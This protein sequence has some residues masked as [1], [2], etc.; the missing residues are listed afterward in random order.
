MSGVVVTKGHKADFKLATLS[1]ILGYFERKRKDNLLK[2]KQLS[3]FSMSRS[4]ISFA[5]QLAILMTALCI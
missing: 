4:L 5:L 1:P 2:H 3:T